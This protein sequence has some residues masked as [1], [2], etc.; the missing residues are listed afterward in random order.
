MGLSAPFI[1]IIPFLSFTP[2]SIV[3]IL[4]KKISLANEKIW[5]HFSGAN[6]PEAVPEPQAAVEKPV[7]APADQAKPE[8][9]KKEKAAPAD[10]PEKKPQAEEEAIHVGR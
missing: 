3:G 4:A 6:Q 7:A 1:K 9:K 10:K 8:K 5:C 2:L